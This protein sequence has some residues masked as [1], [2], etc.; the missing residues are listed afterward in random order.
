MLAVWA[1]DNAIDP[2]DSALHAKRCLFTATTKGITEKSM[3]VR[4]LA[5]APIANCDATNL[6]KRVKRIPSIS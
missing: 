1:L 3:G 4:V 5:V 6:D 2:R